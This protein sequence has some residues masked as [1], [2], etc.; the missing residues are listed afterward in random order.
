MCEWKVTNLHLKNLLCYHYLS[1][2]LPCFAYKIATVWP[3]LFC[4]AGL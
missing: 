4:K 2:I 1:G 3:E